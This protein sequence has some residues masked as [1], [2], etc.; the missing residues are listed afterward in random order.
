MKLEDFTCARR[1]Y[2]AIEVPL[3]GHGDE[4]NGGMVMLSSSM[5]G[6]VHFALAIMFLRY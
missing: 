3:K 6:V 5:F 1:E 2:N 4:C